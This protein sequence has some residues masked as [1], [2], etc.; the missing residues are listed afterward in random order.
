VI[1]NII[2]T[3][4]GDKM[5]IIGIDH[6]A[7]RVK[8]L[9]KA[10]DFFEDLFDTKFHEL[11]E[12]PALDIISYIDPIGLELVSPLLPD[13]PTRRVLD[14]RGEGMTV[15][16]LKVDDLDKAVAEMEAKGVRMTHRGRNGDLEGAVFHPS[17]TFGVLFELVEYKKEEHPIRTTIKKNVG[18]PLLDQ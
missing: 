8:Y 5:K 16:S 6:I 11:G 4:K 15:L 1:K 9:K 17:D 18:R 12:V 2:I 10:I 14:R 3:Q 7:I 13:G